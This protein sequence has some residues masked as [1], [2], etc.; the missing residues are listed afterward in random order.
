VRLSAVVVWSDHGNRAT[1]VEALDA[2]GVVVAVADDYPRGREQVA[3]MEPDVLITELRLGAYNGLHLVLRAKIERPATTAIV[4]TRTPDPVLQL[5]ATQ[6]DATLL[7]IKDTGH[8]WV[9]P[10]L[11]AI[12]PRLGEG[13]A[14][15]VKPIE[16]D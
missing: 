11:A 7:V 16:G 4:L 10:V 14:L 1:L 12:A 3:I 15:V 2:L 13:S 5:E 6:L 9:A 8:G